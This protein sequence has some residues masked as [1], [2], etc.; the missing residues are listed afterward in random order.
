MTEEKKDP[1][2]VLRMRRKDAGADGDVATVT[3]KAFEDGRDSIFK[4]YVLVDA[5]GKAMKD[6]AASV[7]ASKGGDA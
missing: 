1:G 3:R 4:D 5:E 6:A 2:E 7:S